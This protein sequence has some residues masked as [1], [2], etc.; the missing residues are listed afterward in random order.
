MGIA[1]LVPCEEEANRSRGQA[2]PVGHTEQGIGVGELSKEHGAVAVRRSDER[3]VRR[4][5]DSGEGDFLE[6][7]AVGIARF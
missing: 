3:R 7:G 1:E 4:A 6:I 2:A 5:L